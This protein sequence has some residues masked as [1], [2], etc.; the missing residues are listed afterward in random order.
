MCLTRQIH[1]KS[2][3]LHTMLFY[4]SLPGRLHTICI[5]NLKMATSY[6]FSQYKNMQSTSVTEP[7]GV[8]L[9]EI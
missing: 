6:C 4:G 1:H 2:Q 5:N 8:S 7:V 3:L 9:I